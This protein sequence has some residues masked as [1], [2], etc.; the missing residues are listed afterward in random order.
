VAKGK[1]CPEGRN[2]GFAQKRLKKTTLVGFIRLAHFRKRLYNRLMNLIEIKNA[3]R[4]DLLDYLEGMRIEVD[5][6]LS[7]KALRDQCRDLYWEFFA[8]NDGFARES[9]SGAY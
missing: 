6:T 2:Q 9:I 1:H 8:S 5:P 3:S 4:I 7:N